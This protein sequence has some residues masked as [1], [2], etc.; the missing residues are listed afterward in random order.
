M[1]INISKPVDLGLNSVIF[2]LILVNNLDSPVA[3]SKREIS[4]HSPISRAICHGGLLKIDQ[5][6]KQDKSAPGGHVLGLTKYEKPLKVRL[7]MIF[8]N[9]KFH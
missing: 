6:R 8:K 7:V 5:V 2:G 4:V 3:D 1:P 9:C